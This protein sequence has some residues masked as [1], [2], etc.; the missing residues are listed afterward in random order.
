[1]AIQKGG[2]KWAMPAIKGPAPTSPA[3]SGK[4]SSVSGASKH[5]T[6]PCSGKEMASALSSRNK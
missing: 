3:K 2:G 1:M 5:A 4:S 6:T